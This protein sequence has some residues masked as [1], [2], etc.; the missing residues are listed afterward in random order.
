MA[1]LSSSGDDYRPIKNPFNN[2][3]K[4]VFPYYK[5]N[6]FGDVGS[7][8]VVFIDHTESNYFPIRFPK[9]QQ[10]CWFFVYFDENLSTKVKKYYH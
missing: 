9:N 5:N 1:T 10:I 2:Q 6:L 4:N 7:K 8:N 3:K